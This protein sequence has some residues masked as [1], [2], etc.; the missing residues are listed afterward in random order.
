MIQ[1][2]CWIS[3][4]VSMF[5]GVGRKTEKKWRSASSIR[6]SPWNLPISPHIAFTFHLLQLK[7][8]AYIQVKERL[9]NRVLY[10]G[11]QLYPQKKKNQAFGYRRRRYETSSLCKRMHKRRIWGWDN[12][13]LYLSSEELVIG[14]KN[15]T[16]RW[17]LKWH[18]S[19][20]TT[21]NFIKLKLFWTS[22]NT[23]FPESFTFELYIFHKMWKL[24]RTFIRHPGTVAP[25]KSPGSFSK[26]QI[27][28]TH[29]WKFN[30]WF[31][32]EA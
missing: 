22:Y 32:S 2:D 12:L 26:I 20:G 6:V 13:E 14:K 18:Y 25:S 19:S 4:T 3:A 16:E 8:L 29:S 28:E 10:L 11:T 17:R 24:V 9:R 21:K 27:P 23:N 31:R 1:D 30:R 5:Q 7:S 15:G